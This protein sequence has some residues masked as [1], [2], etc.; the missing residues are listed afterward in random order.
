MQFFDSMFGPEVFGHSISIILL[1]SSILEV[2]C[3]VL[4]VAS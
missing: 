4:L 3:L 1:E 2:G